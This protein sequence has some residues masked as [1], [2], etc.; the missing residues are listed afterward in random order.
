L[1]ISETAG[2]ADIRDAYKRQALRWHPDNVSAENKEVA[3]QRFK[4]I[5]SAYYVLSDDVKRAHYDTA[6][7][8]ATLTGDPMPGHAVSLADA[9]EIFIMF[10]VSACVR[11]FELSADG[12]PCRVVRLVGTL[13]ISAVLA[14][15]GCSGGVAI[16]AVTTALLNSSGAIAIYRD[17][18]EAEKVAFSQAL[19]ILAK[20][21]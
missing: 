15:A 3:T 18:S 16:S 11:Q 9:W 17:L 13:S 8:A 7:A 12:G 14:A 19:M 1:G 20:H 4:A 5:S 6:R 2:A 10:I 21:V